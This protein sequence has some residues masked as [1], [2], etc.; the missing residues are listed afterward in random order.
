VE[1]RLS[2]NLTIRGVGHRPEGLAVV[3][4]HCGC[5]I[6]FGLDFFRTFGVLKFLVVIIC[7]SSDHNAK[8]IAINYQ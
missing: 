7:K 5:W 6:E 3:K 8:S 4:T 2:T 1:E